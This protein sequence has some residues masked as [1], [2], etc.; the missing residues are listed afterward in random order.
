MPTIYEIERVSFKEPYPPA[1]LDYLAS[2]AS[3]TFLV[4]EGNSQVLG[5][6]IATERTDYLGHIISIAVHPGHR[7]KGLGE[8]LMKSIIDLLAR[9]G[10]STIRL[11]V[12]RDNI[13]AQSLYEKFGFK[14][15][16]VIEDYYSDGEDALVFLKNL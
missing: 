4:V 16:Y 3:D 2:C 10:I 8:L 12:R 9:K 5:Y 7:R 6:V 15:A 1:Y 14:L 11:E 13:V